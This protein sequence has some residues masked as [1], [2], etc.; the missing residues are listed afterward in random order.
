MTKKLLVIASSLLFI[1]GCESELDKCMEANISK[2][3]FSS[4]SDVD[5]VIEGDFYDK[6]GDH[7]LFLELA[8]PL[9][10]EFMTLI[11][12]AKEMNCERGQIKDVRGEN[13]SDA[14]WENTKEQLT[15]EYNLYRQ[16]EE[17]IAK[18]AMTTL[19]NNQG[20]Y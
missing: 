11:S 4:F 16:V 18:E 14:C 7:P 5:G 10:K 8:E 20:I 19:C 2:I 9:Q 3:T 17:A 1:V 15:K 13:E 6:V 12:A